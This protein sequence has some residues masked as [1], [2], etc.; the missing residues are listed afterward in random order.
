METIVFR[1]NPYDPCVANNMIRDKKITITRHF[2]DLKVSHSDKYI[3]DVLIQCS[4]DTYEYITKLKSSRVKIHDYLV[5][6]LDN[7][8][9]REVKIY[10]K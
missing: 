7:T 6:T 4:K 8:T 9:P 1:V 10:L 5:M 2:N 3:V